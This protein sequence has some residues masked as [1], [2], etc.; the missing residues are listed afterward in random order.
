MEA[1]KIK[2]PKDFIELGQYYGYP[3]CCIAEFIQ[4]VLDLKDGK[5]SV[6]ERRQLNGTGYVPCKSCNDKTKDQLLET[7]TQLR[8]CKLPFPLG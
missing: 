5:N 3:P 1:A 7:I 4:F 6:R 2:K 8:N